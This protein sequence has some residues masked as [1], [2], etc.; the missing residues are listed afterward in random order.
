MKIIN[1]LYKQ[2]L[3]IKSKP[4]FGRS[5]VS[6]EANGKLCFFAKMAEKVE[7]YPNTL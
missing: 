4:H 3:F 5:S 6:M 2:I 7:M 1:G